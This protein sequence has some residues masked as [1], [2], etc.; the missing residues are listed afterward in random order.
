[1][2]A[3]QVVAA[4]VKSSRRDQRRYSAHLI[5]AAILRWYKVCK[6]CPRG[7]SSSAAAVHDWA[8][9]TAN[10]ARKMV[11]CLRTVEI[12]NVGIHMH[13]TC[14]Y[15]TLRPLCLCGV[16][17]YVRWYRDASI[18]VALLE[19]TKFKKLCRSSKSSRTRAMD[20]LK[21]ELY[22]LLP[23]KKERKV[24][25]CKKGEDEAAG[26]LNT[27]TGAWGYNGTTC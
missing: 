4:I 27:Q 15:V 3:A 13:H 16:R 12:G 21:Q 11:A 18:Y 22:A 7:I 8:L 14:V 24:R 17:L 19:A 9:R 20:E 1:M 6:K 5:S 23:R 26:S 2:A 25:N 10:A